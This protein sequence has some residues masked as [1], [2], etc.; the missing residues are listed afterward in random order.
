MIDA[1]IAELKQTPLAALGGVSAFFAFLVMMLEKTFVQRKSN[2]TIAQTKFEGEA[3]TAFSSSILWSASMA[4]LAII[5]LQIALVL[6]LAFGAASYAVGL[7]ALDRNCREFR[8]RNNV[9]ASYACAAIVSAIIFGIF[10]EGLFRLAAPLLNASAT[11]TADPESF[12]IVPI[13]ILGLASVA[14]VVL[15]FYT[16]RSGLSD[17]L[18]GL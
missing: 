4:T 13:M 18:E 16:A 14:G 8:I 5:L 1:A 3:L 10:W 9:A 15:Y 6:G 11:T 2:R 12:I 7:Y 17:V